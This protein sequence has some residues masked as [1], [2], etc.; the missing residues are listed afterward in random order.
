MK[1]SLTF[2]K[3][4]LFILISF[5]WGSSFELMKLGLF[6]NHDLSKPIL[7]S[8]QV[9]S[10]R[11]VS[12]GLVLVPFVPRYLKKIA[13]ADLR[14]IALS[15]LLGSLI[16]AFLFTLAE[17]KIDGAFAGTLNSLT[18]IFVI[19]VAA[20]FFSKQITSQALKGILIAFIGSALVFYFNWSD[21]GR[22]SLGNVSFAWFCVLA[23]F[24]YGLNVNMVD[25]VMANTHPLAVAVIAFASLVIPAFIA[26]YLSGY[27]SL[28]LS[29]S[30]YIIATLAS[31][32][33]GII[34][35]TVAS[36]LFYKL[37]QQAGYLFASM[38]TYGI[39]FIAQF[40]GWVNGEKVDV[41]TLLGLLIILLGI[42]TA[43]KVKKTIV[44]D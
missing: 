31:V 21:H 20:F 24:F 14:Y 28:P 44:T 5:I 26:L 6:E 9:A 2:S 19:I 22:N 18:P 4:G 1:N 32:T 15:G 34:G 3:W 40:W 43:T 41:F 8:W 35:T 11:L 37:M 12:A 42:Y 16:P 29:E 7:S 13:A 27:F 39:P 38:V 25:K 33:L 10:L 36:L 23:T 30:K 17:T